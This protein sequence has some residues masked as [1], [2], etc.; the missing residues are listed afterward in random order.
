[1]T[2]GNKKRNGRSF[3]E[4]WLNM[5]KFPGSEL[6]ERETG[7]RHRN[8]YH[9]HF[10]GYTEVRRVNAKGRVVSERHYTAPW[11]LHSLTD[12]QWVLT[13]L[14]YVLGT[15]LTTSLYFWALVQRVPSNSAALVAIPGFLSVLL[16][17]LLWMAVFAYVSA[18]R[19]MTLWEYRSG[20]NKIEL[21]TR[22]FA[23]GVL[24]TVVAKIIFICV[25]MDLS[26]VGEIAGLVALVLSAVPPVLIFVVERKMNYEELENSALV[27]EEERYD[28]Q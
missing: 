11:Q 19:K 12:L 18:P 25:W 23:A 4:R 13:K 8:Y 15:V 1:M 5:G 28:I 3:M 17:V 22:L 26:W 9:K 27:T 7:F 14:A 2:V 21:F 20:K 16:L 6:G 10:M 24:A